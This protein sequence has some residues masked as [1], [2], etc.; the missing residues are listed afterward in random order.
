MAQLKDFVT[1]F[2][3]ASPPKS[4][5]EIDAFG[6]TVQVGNNGRIHIHAVHDFENAQCVLIP[7]FSI[8]GE[9]FAPLSKN[10]ETI[11]V[12]LESSPSGIIITD[13]VEGTLVKMGMVY[14]GQTSGLVTI[15]VAT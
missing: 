11:S 15:K 2:D 7:V 8:D 10:G 5:P 14:G 13:L 3:M 12:A 9:N 4:P 1:D 6:E